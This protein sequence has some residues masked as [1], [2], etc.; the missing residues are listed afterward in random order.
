M[1]YVKDDTPTRECFAQ[2]L[3][4][5][6]IEPTWFSRAVAAVQSGTYRPRA[7]TVADRAGNAL[8]AVDNDGVAVVPVEGQI[9]KGDSKFGG[10]S[11]IRARQAVRLAARSEDV[12]G[13]VLHIDSPGGTVAGTAELADEVRA[14]DRR[15]PV[16]SHIDDLGASAAYW[17]ASQSRRVAVNATGEVG[18][19]GVFAVL[20]DTSGAADLAGVKVHV[21]ASGEY[22]GVGID[23]VQVTDEQIESVRERVADVHELFVKAVSTGRRMKVADVRKVADGRVWIA[24]K[25]KGL[26][27]IDAVQPFETTRREVLREVE[28]GER[29]RK[30]ARR[31]AESRLD[32]MSDAR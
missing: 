8:Y 32:M 22:K 6:L 12:R 18:S 11:S 26:G 5:W 14:A 20:E 25:A 16:V 17:V 23:G 15:K 30:T 2:H 1:Q 21:V 4:P 7:E 29:G 31:L 28:R 27:L 24:D 19:I 3:G 9:V 10:T 13:I